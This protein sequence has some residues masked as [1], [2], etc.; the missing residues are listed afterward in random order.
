MVIMSAKEMFD[1]KDYER[2]KNII[3]DLIKADL[4]EKVDD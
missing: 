1:T 4:V 2:F 3:N